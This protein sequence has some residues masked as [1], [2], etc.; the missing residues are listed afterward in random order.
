MIT[1]VGIDIERINFPAGEMHI[2]VNT[3]REFRHSTIDADF[4]F[5]KNEDLIELL[6]FHDALKNHNLVLDTLRI[7]YMPFG[8]QDRVTQPGESFSLRVVANLINSMNIRRV[9]VFDPHSDVTPALIHNC[10]VIHQREIFADQLNAIT[11]ENREKY[12]LIS[13]DGGALKKIYLLARQVRDCKGVIECSKERNT[14]TGEITGT[15]VHCTPEKLRGEMCVIV[16]DICDGGRTFV[17]LAKILKN[18]YGV[19][20]I[21]LCVSHGLFT[22]GIGVFDGLIDE[23]YTLK[24]KVK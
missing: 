1:A 20:T 13:P 8:R 7:G 19:K 11:S 15:I 14:S 18:N 12:F 5:S 3:N 2:R 9:V 21:I 22:K 24:G 23:I 4:H 16:D 17:E 6:L 10:V